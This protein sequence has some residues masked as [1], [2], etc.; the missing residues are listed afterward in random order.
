MTFGFLKEII[1]KT[2]LL[3]QNLENVGKEIFSVMQFFGWDTFPLSLYLTD[4][5]KGNQEFHSIPKVIF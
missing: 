3:R 4:L 5:F 1:K 2:T